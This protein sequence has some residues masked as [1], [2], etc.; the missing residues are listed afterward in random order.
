MTR[1][2]RLRGRTGAGNASPV[3][4]I[5]AAF[6]AV[7]VV[8]L[9]VGTEI[10]RLIGLRADRPGLTDARMLHGADESVLWRP[11]IG[12]AVPIVATA[13]A[14]VGVIA[15]VS[16]VRAG[17][18]AGCQVALLKA[19]AMTVGAT[20][21]AAF[22]PTIVLP[23]GARGGLAGPALAGCT[24]RAALAAGAAIGTISSEVD[25]GAVAKGQSG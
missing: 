8:V 17:A 20:L 5:E 22:G 25:A 21:P 6:A 16:L 13:P 4:A 15:D 12:A 19:A 11:A 24:R 18:S 7:L 9:Q 2:S 1:E 23:T 14:D 10:A 3:L